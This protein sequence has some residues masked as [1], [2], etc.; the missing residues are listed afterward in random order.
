MTTLESCPACSSKKIRPYSHTLEAERQKAI[1]FAQSYCPNCD[2]VFSNPMASQQGLELYYHSQY[3][4]EAEGDYNANHPD[5]QSKIE[6]R[7]EFAVKGLK[8]ML[9]PYQI[10]SGVFFEIGAS[11]GAVLEAAHRLGF[12]VAGVEPSDKVFQFANEVLGLKT[13]K[14]GMFEP[15][16]WPESF[17]DVIYSH[18]VI[19][20]VP[21][22]EKFV[23]G[24][25]RMLKSGRLAIVG[26]ENHHN[27]WVPY[28]RVRNWLKGRSLP[29]FQTSD[30]HTFY[31]SDRSLRYVLEKNGFEIIKCWVYTHSL[32][33]KLRT[34]HF[35]S[36]FSKAFFYFMHYADVWTGRG[37][38]LV[39]WCRKPALP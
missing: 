23:S 27:A 38:R 2:L 5:L 9:F 18:H 34:A 39:I 30:H 1:H 24:M 3:Y 22:L 10:T 25:F 35:R 28:R 29:E 12:S 15:M 37:N 4:E 19:E 14:H 17:C 16:D 11:Y 31:F 32:Q 8:D 7:I 20:H 26:T 6:E 13:L 36:I 33:E 21:D